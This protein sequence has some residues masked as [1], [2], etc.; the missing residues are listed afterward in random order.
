MPVSDRVCQGFAQCDFNVALSLRNTAVLAES[1]HEP[2]HDRENRGHLAWQRALQL[3]TRAPWLWAMVIRVHSLKA[4]RNS[5]NDHV[6]SP[7]RSIGEALDSV[8]LALV[9]SSA[10]LGY[11]R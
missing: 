5:E 9:A 4:P 2:I 6:R 1:H 10:K 8:V 11:L 7:R 3:N